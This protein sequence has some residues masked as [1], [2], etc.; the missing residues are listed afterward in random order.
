MGSRKRERQRGRVI[1][2]R[3]TTKKTGREFTEQRQGQNKDKKRKKIKIP[4]GSN[5]G[6]GEK[7]QEGEDTDGWKED[8]S[9]EYKKG[10]EGTQGG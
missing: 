1:R 8:W 2:S 3:A 6:T 4:I 5:L 7:G 9:S 10:G